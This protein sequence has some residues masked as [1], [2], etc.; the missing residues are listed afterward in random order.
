MALGTESISITL[1]SACKYQRAWGEEALINAAHRRAGP[2]GT[3]SP[4]HGDS[5]RRSL[6]ASAFKS[7]HCVS[8]WLGLVP[9]QNSSGVRRSSAASP[10]PAPKVAA[11]ALANNTARIVWA[12]MTNG[13]RYKEPVAI[14]SAP[15]FRR[16]EVITSV[17][18]RRRWP[19]SEK[20]RLMAEAVQ[21]GQSVSY[22][23]RR[24]G[25]SPPSSLPGS[26]ACSKADHA[27]V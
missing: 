11:V 10:R 6:L 22:V 26:P 18:R 12:L 7:G 21:P 15:G 20:V 5:W 9:K 16:V 23:A 4:V 13:E 24:A 2:L 8:A 3:R 25:I 14:W 1:I 27:A 17:Q 19:V